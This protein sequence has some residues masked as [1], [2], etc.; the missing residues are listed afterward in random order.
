[1]E[2]PT[3]RGI[4]SNRRLADRCTALARAFPIPGEDSIVKDRQ[5]LIEVCE[6]RYGHHVRD[7]PLPEV[8]CYAK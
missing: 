4:Q 3:A 1:M 7:F 2:L 6:S 8:P 5:D